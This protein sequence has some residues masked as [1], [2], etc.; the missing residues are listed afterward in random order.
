MKVSNLLKEYFETSSVPRVRQDFLID[1]RSL[2]VSPVQKSSWF[3]KQSPERLCRTYE[4]GNRSSCKNFINEIL[5][6][7]D[8]CEH[9]AEIRCKGSNIVIEVF[10][11][12]V[13]C[14]TE[15]DKDYAR[16]ADAIYDEMKYYD[17]R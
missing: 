11:H 7:E 8:R 1:T 13:D 6:Y 2:P 9:H 16:E 17:Y 10:T 5:D 4:F 3:L 14:V 12:G 15:L